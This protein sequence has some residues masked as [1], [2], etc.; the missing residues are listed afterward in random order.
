MYKKLS[1]TLAALV[2]VTA[3]PNTAFGF[4]NPLKTYDLYADTHRP[5]A[6]AAT[7]ERETV[8]GEY[9]SNSLRPPGHGS[10]EAAMVDN[11]EKRDNTVYDANGVKRRNQVLRES[12]LMIYANPD[13]EPGWTQGPSFYKNPSLESIKTKYKKSNFAGCLQESISYVRLH[14]SDTLGFYYLAMSYAK[15]NDKDNAVKA[16]ERVIALNDNPMIVKYATNGRNCVMGN[17]EACYQ[18]VNVPELIYPYANIAAGK[19]AE[20][21]TIIDPQ[22]LVNRN[23]DSLYNQM[24]Q[25]ADSKDGK[26]KDGNKKNIDLPF[27]TQDENLDQFIRAPYGTGLSPELEK[28]YKQIQLRKLQQNMNSQNSSSN[29]MGDVQSF[30]QN[31]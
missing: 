18:N 3:L 22:T 25:V 2:A 4:Q 24:S 13:T 31:N 28:E 14:P 7:S 15:V 17:N 6:T 29:N 20:E 9:Y 26:G 1:L 30:D 5:T 27:N 10:G 11:D 8:M 19:T 12:A 23:M 16:Y 21:M